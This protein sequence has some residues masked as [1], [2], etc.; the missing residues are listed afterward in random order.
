MRADHYGTKGNKGHDESPA[1]S[2]LAT[3]G[4]LYPSIKLLALAPLLTW[5]DILHNS[6]IFIDSGL[7]SYGGFLYSLV[8]TVFFSLIMF[9][10]GIFSRKS[11]H[12]LKNRR[13]TVAAGLLATAGTLM[14][15]YTGNVLPYRLLFILGSALTGIGTSWLFFQAAKFYCTKKPVSIFT[16]AAFSKLISIL[17]YFFVL[18]L[19]IP[20]SVSVLAFL[21][22]IAVAFLFMDTPA[23][24]RKDLIPYEEVVPKSLKITY[25]KLFFVSFVTYFVISYA[26]GRTLNDSN[27]YGEYFGS[28]IGIGILLLCVAFIFA[29]NTPRVN[30]DK[31]IGFAYLSVPLIL[32]IALLAAPYFK[33]AG[34]W[35]DLLSSILF[36]IFDILLWGIF[37]CMVYVHRQQFAQVFGIGRGFTSAGSVC[38]LCVGYLSGMFIADFSSA[39]IV[40]SIISAI[41]LVIML[42]LVFSKNDV[43]LLV[44]PAYQKSLEDERKA[45][46][47][48]IKHAEEYAWMDIFSDSLCLTLRER[49]IIQWLFK[50]RTASYIAKNLDLSDNTVKTHIRNIYRK[51]GVN[52]REELLDLAAIQDANVG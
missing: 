27:V 11:N 4:G 49:E 2:F 26:T 35:F 3:I 20:M 18:S 51:A 9:A 30:G 50:G 23:S 37:A 33:A 34:G 15:F 43:E 8:S 46:R 5:A 12:L 42:T 52:S 45:R 36:G 31:L 40:N 7:G 1:S 6:S 29:L 41:V 48:A 47:L 22:C 16:F 14:F 17:L 19:P 44:S 24:H 13:L 38:G 25:T 21:P 28:Y 39:L 32:I 10:S